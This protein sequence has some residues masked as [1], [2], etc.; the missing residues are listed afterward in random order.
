VAIR[1]SAF[2]EDRLDAAW[3]GQFSTFL[4]VTGL[5]SIMAHLKE[6]WAGFWNERA[7]Q[8]R[9]A[10]VAPAGGGLIIQRMVVPR[11]AGVL[12]TVSVAT[13][14]LRTMVANV[15]LGLGAGIVS[16]EVGVDEIRI[17][18]PVAADSPI[19]DVQYRIGDKRDQLVAAPA[20]SG[21]AR[22]ETVYHQRFRA[23]LEYS[24]VY[25]LATAGRLLES[26]LGHPLDI[27]FAFEG[28]DLRVLQL[29]PI[30]VFYHALTETLRRFPFPARQ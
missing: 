17:V 11:V 1:S 19:T 20:G 8:R 16:G 9:G 14:E 4:N 21:V 12:H 5:E 18:R 10:N 24:E 22:V 7:L 13:A 15:G 30:P 3:A 27:E 29:R 28:D 23:A 2:E 6:A 26:V 25:E